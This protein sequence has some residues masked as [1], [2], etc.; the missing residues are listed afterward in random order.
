M[1]CM[2]VTTLADMEQPAEQG[3]RALWLLLLTSQ[4]KQA[5]Q[6]NRLPMDRGSD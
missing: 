1:M 4:S 3:D 5:R 2:D 6:A